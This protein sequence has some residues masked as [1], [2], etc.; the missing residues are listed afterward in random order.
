LRVKA[1]PRPSTPEEFGKLIGADLPRWSKL[2]KDTNIK[3]S[4]RRCTERFACPT[5]FA[6]HCHDVVGSPR[7]RATACAHEGWSRRPI[8]SGRRSFRIVVIGHAA[9]GACD[10]FSFRALNGAGTNRRISALADIIPCH[11]SSV[12]SLLRS[13]D[14]DVALIRIKPLRA[15]VSRWGDLGFHASD[16]RTQARAVI[17]LVNPPCR[18]RLAMPG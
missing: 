7:G 6:D 12:P 8:S 9:P 10:H 5:A 18:S 2:I 16:D 1:G 11:V 4:E 15:V 17:A 3:V 13:G 14:C